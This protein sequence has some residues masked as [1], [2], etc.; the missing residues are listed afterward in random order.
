MALVTCRGCGHYYVTTES[1]ARQPL[2]C[3]PCDK[4]RR[5]APLAEFRRYLRGR[6]SPSALSMRD[7]R[8][9]E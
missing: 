2:R 3:P 8:G 9:R 5:F 4:S 7:Y 1:A 6:L